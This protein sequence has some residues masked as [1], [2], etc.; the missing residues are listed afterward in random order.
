MAYTTTQLIADAY[1]LSG[2]VAR[3]FQTVSGTQAIDGLRLLNFFLAVKTA[4]TNLV[5]YYREFT[6]PAVVNQQNYFVENLIG[7]E[8]VTFE[9]G[10]VRYAVDILGRKDYYGTSRVN[11]VPSLMSTVRCERKKGG[12]NLAFYFTPSQAF[13]VQVWGKAGLDSVTGTEDLED[14]Y[15]LFYIE[16][17]RH[18]LAEYICSDNGAT[19]Q[20]QAAKRLDELEQIL[21]QISPPD[22]SV[23]KLSSLTGLGGLTMADVNVGHN[24]RPL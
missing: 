23:R 22:L 6:F 17:L 12:M 15:D 2:I 9:L 5:P 19:F 16:Y 18:G 1:Y 11:N 24:W 20:P 4:D 3:E 13:P 21:S 7:V 8:T 14:T 10:N